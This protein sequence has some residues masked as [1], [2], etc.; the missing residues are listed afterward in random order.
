MENDVPL[1]ISADELKKEVEAFREARALRL[2]APRGWL[3]LVN[4]V[5][6]EDGDYLVGSDEHAEIAV[7][8]GKAPPFLA[9]VTRQ[10]STVTLRAA[11]G[12]VLQARGEPQT[13]LVLR[14]DGTPNADIVTYG[15]LSFEL[16]ARGDDF[17]LRVR[18]SESALRRDFQGIDAYPVD[19]TWRIVGRL[20][21]YEKEREVIFEDGDGR[22][23]QYLAPGVV[24]LDRDGRTFRVEPVFESERRRLFLLFNDATNAD[25]TY[26]AGRFLYADLP[27]G[28]RLVLD[29]NKAFNPPCAFTPYAVCPLPSPEN[30][31]LIRVEAGEKRPPEPAE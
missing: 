10:G 8:A 31:L 23:Q 22:P 29:F 6:L 3:T 18:D 21:H 11:P 26:G 28:D 14:P 2:T 17:A 7:P 9:T 30:R 5:W 4:K 12:V 15:S 16:L 27:V 25:T 24:E 20:R 1:Q 13:S 19:P